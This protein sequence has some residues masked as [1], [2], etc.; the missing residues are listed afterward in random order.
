LSPAELQ[1]LT[2]FPTGAGEPRVLDAAGMTAVRARWFPDGKRLLVAAM[3][4]RGGTRLWVRQVGGGEPRPISPEGIRGGWLSI[5]PDG[6]LVAAIDASRRMMLYPV[7]GGEPR[8]VPGIEPE[9]K[10]FRFA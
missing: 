10:P 3:T 4:P 7:A 9:E 5:S 1:P 6:S 8:P 2:I